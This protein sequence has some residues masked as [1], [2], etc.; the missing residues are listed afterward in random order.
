MGW[1]EVSAGI[2]IFCTLIFGI[3]AI[4]YYFRSAKL[5]KAIG[6]SHW[7]DI[8]DHY[9]QIKYLKEAGWKM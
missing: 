1:T 6:A 8:S 3:I 5:M 9:P 7:T 2:G 4:L